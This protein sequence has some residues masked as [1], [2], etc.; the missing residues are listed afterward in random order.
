MMDNLR[1]AANHVVLKIILALIILSF[2]LTGVGN[3]L[4]GGSEDSRLW[5]RV[6]VSDGLSYSVGSALNASSWEPS[7]S[8]TLFASMAPQNADAV[9]KA[10][11]AVLAN[12]LK[13][14]FTQA[15]VDQGVKS[16]L[17]YLQLGR[18]SDA[19]LSNRWSDYLQTGRS[20]AWQTH[21][22]NALKALTADAVNSAM[23]E[24]LHPDDLTIAIAA[25]PQTTGGR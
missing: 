5:Q 24:V 6:R 14:G 21:I 19:Y 10:I 25:A 3:Y 2:V 4:I 15:E 1:A 20:F 17:N 8:W 16:L 13:A 23:R 18:S 7:G 9:Q 11:A 12:T 22:Q